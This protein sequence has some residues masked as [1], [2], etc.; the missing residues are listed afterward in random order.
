MGEGE[1]IKEMSAAGMDSEALQTELAQ[2]RSALDNTMTAIM[3]VDTD[4]V[5][6]YTN[7]ATKNLLKQHEATLR[8]QHPDFSGDA[9]L[10]TSI[11]LFHQEFV[12]QRRI[13]S[14]PA[15]LPLSVD[16][17]FGPLIL[18]LNVATQYDGAGK[19]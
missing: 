5:I 18:N 7:Q 3:I 9:V 1:A 13:W 16:I 11:D 2:L 17:E 19:Y 14:D 6:T 12:R 15:N 10:G 8:E 4:F